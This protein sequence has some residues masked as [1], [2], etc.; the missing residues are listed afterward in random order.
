MEIWRDGEME[1]E[2][3]RERE[4]EKMCVHVCV[5]ETKRVCACERERERVLVTKDHA[6]CYH[7]NLSV[8]KHYRSNYMKER[9]KMN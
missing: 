7:K 9:V 3:Y 5:I 6:A 8:Q 4:T 2:S 1:R